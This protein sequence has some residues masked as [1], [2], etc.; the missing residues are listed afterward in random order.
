MPHNFT[1]QKK[2]NE[3][4]LDFQ[5]QIPEIKLVATNDCHYIREEDSETQEVL[6]AIQSNAKWSD[7]NRWRFSVQGLFLRSTEE[8]RKAFIQ[9]G[10]LNGN[11]IEEALNTTMEIAEKCNFQI[12]KKTISLPS[13]PGIG[14]EDP[15]K[16]IFSLAESKLLEMG[17]S[18]TTEKLNTY[19]D[20]LCNEWETIN[21]KGFSQYFVVVWELV[22]WCKENKIMVGP[23]RGSCGGSLLAY[24]LGITTSMD[25]IE[26]GLL[27][28]RFIAEDR[29][30]FPDIDLDFQDDR[31][32]MIREHLEA[33]YGKDHISS[34]STFLTMKARGCIRDVS[35]VFEVP[36]PEVDIFAKSIEE[37]SENGGSNISAALDTDIGKSFCQKYPHVCEH[38]IK[39]E[40]Q[41]RGVG[42]HAAAIIISKE[43]LAE[44]YRGNLALRSSKIVSNWNMADSEYVGLMKLDVLALNTLTV[45]NETKR[46][47]E[48]N[49]GTILEFENIPLNDQ[50]VF[51]MIHAGRTNGV[52][53]L[54]AKASTQL[55]KRIRA[56]NICELSDIIA[57]VRPGP[58]DSGM[59]E[60]YI[61]RKN[62]KTK[63]DP[64]HPI[65]EKITGNTYG[66]IVYQEQ[67]MEVINKVAGLPY[68][69]ADKIRKII[70]KKR[71]VKEF[72]PYKD[73]FV[74][75]CI[76]QKT[77]SKNQAEEFWVGLQKHANYSFNRSHSIA[78]AIIGYWTAWCKFFYPNE[79][80]CASLTY[81]SES[82]K[83]ELLQE[84][85]EMGIKVITPKIGI[86]EPIKWK[87]SKD[88]LYIP[89]IEI[90]G[91]GEKAA[92]RCA[93]IQPT[94]VAVKKGFFWPRKES[95]I[96][97]AGSNIPKSL[98]Q[99]LQNINAFDKNENESL[100][101][102]EYFAF[103]IPGRQPKLHT[104]LSKIVPN[105]NKKNLGTKWLNLDFD[106]VPLKDPKCL[107]QEK[108]YTPKKS[109]S[110]CFDC[111]LREECKQ[112]IYSSP[113]FF[114]VAIIGEAP[115]KDENE[116]GK[117]FV[118]RAGKL[119]WDELVKY[120]LR[121]EDFH[122]G[123]AVKCFPSQSKTPTA[124]QI[125][126]CSEK[127][128]IQELNEIQCR[129]ILAFGNT[130]LQTFL[131]KKSGITQLQEKE[132]T[133]WSEKFSAW[134]CF[135]IHP[136]A[137]LRQDN[138][139]N[140]MLFEM[141]IENF[142]NKI[143]KIQ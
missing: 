79:F 28:S 27:F 83:E 84:A 96:S 120:G 108:S 103:R 71:D 22:K 9:Q 66:N 111:K 2:I 3:Q 142:I 67:V 139:E 125:K 86:S 38:A 129:L 124:D 58:A 134:V 17:K 53:Q 106:R 92:K 126:I 63:W 88:N 4:C 82:K 5:L 121:R 24:L 34:I 11:Q 128:L 16:F 65:Y 99:I 56:N 116:Q 50:G 29:I 7:K 8:M 61:H 14:D 133:Q 64:I 54:S 135:C 26:Y 47:V 85:Y 60:E 127:W 18:W 51:Q 95:N 100:D 117:G 41:C 98:N 72:K 23:A 112:P 13:V 74:K 115:G 105:Y 80:I 132:M 57:L 141:G 59:T 46:L 69:T 75:G 40:G 21:S 118:G 70:G 43:S 44:G 49:T 110:R 1:G 91:V 36:L 101:I 52:F 35:R 143:E 62:E 73:A 122:V 78:Y 107:I 89:F 87:S 93:E 68:S 130:G 39:L 19:F 140:R 104:N 33:I 136:A 138:K 12:K 114:N 131:G 45:L 20:R 97:F 113:G 76:K 109:L 6:L 119:L 81:G 137:I 15:G 102:E 31:V 94:R 32:D 123:N 48:E 55:A 30:D 90:K 10:I 42:Q 37:S 77:L 25:P